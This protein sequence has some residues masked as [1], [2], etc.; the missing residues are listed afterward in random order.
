MGDTV[1]VRLQVQGRSAG[2][3][4]S[5]M[6][7]AFTKIVANEGVVSG[8]FKGISPA[9]LRQCTYGST[10]LAMYDDIKAAFGHVEGQHFPIYKKVA[11]GMTC[12]ALASA[13]FTPVDVVKVRMQADAAGTRYKGMLDAFRTIAKE[14]GVQGLYTGMS[15]T[16]QRAAIVAASELASY[17]VFKSEL[18][19]RQLEDG[20]AAHIVASL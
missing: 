13:I 14:E 20:V 9:L 1:K 5:G 10:R 11:A 17:D 15:P 19:A 12:G 8:L 3:Q 7:D 18:M 6:L 4:Y 16:V 2:K